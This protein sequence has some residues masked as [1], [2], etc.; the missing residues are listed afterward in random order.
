MV[1]IIMA[2]LLSTNDL[3]FN[4]LG[5]FKQNSSLKKYKKALNQNYFKKSNIYK[6]FVNPLKTWNI[7]N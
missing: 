2:L 7:M 5:L 1:S 3:F 4:Y 6:K